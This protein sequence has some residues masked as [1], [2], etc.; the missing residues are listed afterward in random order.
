MITFTPTAATVGSAFTFPTLNTKLPGTLVS[1]QFSDMDVV[2]ITTPS[3]AVRPRLL[4]AR[5][6]I[7]AGIF[8][9]LIVIGFI[10]LRR[11]KPMISEPVSYFPTRITPMS[12][13][14]TLRRIEWE[15]GAV[16]TPIQRTSLIAE[17]ATLEQ[18]Y[19]GRSDSIDAMQNGEA[20][21]QLRGALERWVKV[22]G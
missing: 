21:S 10:A 2:T 13:I 16:L 20:T 17:I 18:T 9:A 4:R 11:R 19:F 12:V 8:C 1:R 7:L 15:H 14:T 6:M 22:A 5:N 3:V